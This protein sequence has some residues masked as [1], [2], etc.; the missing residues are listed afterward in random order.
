MLGAHAFGSLKRLCST[1]ASATS[2]GVL[3]RAFAS[4]LASILALLGLGFVTS[5]IL[6]DATYRVMFG[7][8]RPTEDVLLVDFE[9]ACSNVVAQFQYEPLGATCR[10]FFAVLCSAGSVYLYVNPLRNWQEEQQNEPE[11]GLYDIDTGV[12]VKPDIVAPTHQETESLLPT[13]SARRCAV[14]R[15]ESLFKIKLPLIGIL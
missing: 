15:R 1:L 13:Y 7:N 11:Q 12:T 5:A 2:V 14:G 9:S 6:T 10:V 3:P 8:V 4:I